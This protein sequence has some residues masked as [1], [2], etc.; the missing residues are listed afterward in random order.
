MKKHKGLFICLAILLVLIILAVIGIKKIVFPDDSVSKYG[1]R[2]KDIDNYSI[3]D[4]TFDDMETKFKENELVT[5]F[6]YKITGRIIKIFITVKEDMDIT[7]SKELSS[8]ILET[9]DEDIK[10]YYD[11]LYYVSCDLENDL[12]PLLGNKNKMSSEFVW[13]MKNGGENAK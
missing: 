6:D 4:T 12:Y 2:L 5:K 8:I 11:I 10:S 9:L 1:D 7:K 3:S 13:T